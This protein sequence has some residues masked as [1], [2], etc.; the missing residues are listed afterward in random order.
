ME[1]QKTINSTI[2]L[3]NGTEIPLFG[4]GTWKS[5]GDKELLNAVKWTLES[6]YIHIDTATLYGNEKS[7]GKA[8]K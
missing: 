8:L 3:N 5:K 1:N 7:I 2:T 6:K 4:L